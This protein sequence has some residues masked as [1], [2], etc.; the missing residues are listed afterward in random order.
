MPGL[1]AVQFATEIG[2]QGSDLALCPR[3]VVRCPC[4][5]HQAEDLT[6]MQLQELSGFD[7]TPRQSGVFVRAIVIEK[8]VHGVK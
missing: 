3:N 2:L 4:M 6:Q 7:E 1:T 8:I 5:A